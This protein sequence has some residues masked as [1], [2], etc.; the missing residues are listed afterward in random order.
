MGQLFTVACDLANAARGKDQKDPVTPS[1]RQLS[2]WR[3]GFG[4]AYKF[5]DEAAK[6]INPST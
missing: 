2:K 4:S 1:K 3:R 5:R 6:Q